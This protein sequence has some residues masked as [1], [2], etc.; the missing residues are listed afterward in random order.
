MWVKPIIPPNL[1]LWLEASVGQ[2]SVTCPLQMPGN[3]ERENF[4]FLDGKKALHLIHNSYHEIFFRNRK[5]GWSLD[6][7]RR[8]VQTPPEPCAK[9]ILLF[10][11]S[12]YE[13]WL[14][15][16][17]IHWLREVKNLHSFIHQMFVECLL[18]VRY[19]SRVSCFSS[20]QNWQESLP[21]CGVYFC[22]VATDQGRK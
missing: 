20:E 5:K 10:P 4:F 11:L 19:L 17:F 2:I 9:W 8:H 7:N 18:C 22:V 13:D 6:R 15:G 16:N 12:K 14:G 21:S 3:K 1:G